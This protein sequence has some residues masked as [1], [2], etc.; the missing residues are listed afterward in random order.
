VTHPVTEQLL[1]NGE[2]FC[3]IANVNEEGGFSVAYSFECSLKDKGEDCLFCSINERAKDGVL[4]KVLIKSPK[5]VAQGIS[6][7]PPGRGR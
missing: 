7:G 4:N 3:H 2:K 5:Q 6:P 1:S